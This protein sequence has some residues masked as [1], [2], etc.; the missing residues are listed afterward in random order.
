[1]FTTTA[2]KSEHHVVMLSPEAQRTI[3]FSKERSRFRG[4]LPSH[5]LGGL[6]RWSFR[7]V[8]FAGAQMFFASTQIRD[9]PPEDGS[10]PSLAR[11]WVCGDGRSRAWRVGSH[12][13]GGP[14]RDTR[15]IEFTG[16]VHSGLSA[17]R[18]ATPASRLYARKRDTGLQRSE[19]GARYGTYH[20]PRHPRWSTSWAAR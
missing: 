16:R 9:R 18:I 12:R 11:M 20:P 4:P 17:I 19:L 15:S 13:G 10:I 2:Y 8:S 1:M 6:D 14:P 3:D 5:P 7:S